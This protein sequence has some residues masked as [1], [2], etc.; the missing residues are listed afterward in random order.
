MESLALIALAVIVVIVIFKPQQFLEAEV[1][2][3][4]SLQ[5][6]RLT[7]AKLAMESDE[8]KVNKKFTALVSDYADSDITCHGH[9]DFKK[10]LKALKSIDKATAK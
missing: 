1:E 2:I 3:A 4:Q 9:R 7:R 5:S 8:L 10:Q 6:K